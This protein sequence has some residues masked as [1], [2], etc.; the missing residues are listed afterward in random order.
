M[1]H[2]HRALPPARCDST[3]VAL[4]HAEPS[5][6]EKRLTTAE[7]GHRIRIA[8]ASPYAN[9][10]PAAARRTPNAEAASASLMGFALTRAGFRKN[11]IPK[12]PLD[13]S[14]PGVRAA[15]SAGS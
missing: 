2:S 9:G 4:P 7:A 14:S 15:S 13:T 11:P 12:E 6:R 3:C 5:P 1:I 8:A 10:G